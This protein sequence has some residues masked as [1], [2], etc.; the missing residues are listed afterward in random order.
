[1]NGLRLPRP[2]PLGEPEQGDG[3]PPPPEPVSPP[4]RHTHPMRTLPILIYDGDC[5]FCAHVLD[6]L[7]ATL[8]RWPQSI[9]WQEADLD[10][11]HLTEADVRHAAWWIPLDPAEKQ[12][13][14]M[15]FS[16]LLSWQHSPPWRLLGAALRTP[17]LSWLSRAAYRLVARNR[18]R[19]PGGSTACLA[20]VRPTHDSDTAPR[21]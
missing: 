12:S 18:H 8:P 14:A 17:P 1:M 10:E 5:G 13:G 2:A 4:K 21:R 15:A 19:L 20:S 9:P 16:A 3:R 6:R 7:R 11:H